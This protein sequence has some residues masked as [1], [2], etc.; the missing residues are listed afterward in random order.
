MLRLTYGEP[1][2]RMREFGVMIKEIDGRFMP[3]TVVLLRPASGNDADELTKISSFTKNQPVVRDQ[4]TV[5][6]CENHVCKLP[7]THPRELAE[8]LDQ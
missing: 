6:V 1:L 8:L 3:S 2:H 7:V 4:T 5:Y